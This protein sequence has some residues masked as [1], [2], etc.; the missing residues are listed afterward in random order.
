MCLYSSCTLE[1]LPYIFCK[2]SSVKDMLDIE[3]TYFVTTTKTT[4]RI[5]AKISQFLISREF[6]SQVSS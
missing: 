1:A 3:Q 5:N 4:S 6:S 2:L